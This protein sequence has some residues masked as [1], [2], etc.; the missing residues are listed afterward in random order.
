MKIPVHP[1]SGHL[2]MFPQQP[3]GAMRA[4]GGDGEK[5]GLGQAADQ[6][7]EVMANAF[8]AAESGRPGAAY[9]NLPKDVQAA[10]CV[11]D[12]LPPPAFSGLGP[13]D[14]SA[15]R[16]AARLINAADNPVVLLGNGLLMPRFALDFQQAPG[17]IDNVDRARMTGSDEQA[18][19]DPTLP[20]LLLCA[21]ERSAPGRNV[22]PR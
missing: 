20:G 22:I 12:P 6:I 16:E 4:A 9:V 19:A 18:P 11:H 21:K 13:A 1:P 5:D 7:S 8:R 14:A 2:V 15:I 17:P 3:I 10:S